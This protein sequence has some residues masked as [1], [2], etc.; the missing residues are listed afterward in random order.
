VKTRED[1]AAPVPTSVLNELKVW[2]KL[3]TE[4]QGPQVVSATERIF[5]DLGPKAKFS[6]TFKMA[7][8]RAGLRSLTFHDL[9]R[10]FLNRCRENG[11]P[12][13]VAMALSGHKS[14]AV[15]QK[16]YREIPWTDLEEA[17]RTM[18]SRRETTG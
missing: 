8:K 16:Y 9:R 11:V 13:E 5:S 15:V 10:V 6:R 17:T 18:E 1:Y 7:A 2:R 12:L 4:T 3:L 14:I